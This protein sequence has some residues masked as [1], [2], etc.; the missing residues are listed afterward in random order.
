MDGGTKVRNFRSCTCDLKS[1]GLTQWS[2][3]FEP[4]S[5]RFSYLVLEWLYVLSTTHTTVQQ[6]QIILDLFWCIWLLVQ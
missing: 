5:R 6:E 4:A 2:L 1:R 3:I